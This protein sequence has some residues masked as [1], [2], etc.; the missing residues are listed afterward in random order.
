MSTLT[1]N[2]LTVQL[3][4]ISL[5]AHGGRLQ[6]KLFNNLKL[7]RTVLYTMTEENNV[8]NWIQDNLR[9]II[10]I[11]IVLLLVFAI[12]SY[13]KRNA[14]TGVIVD[15]SQINE[16][17]MTATNNNDEINQ[18]IDE[19]KD[20][21]KQEIAVTTTTPEPEGK[22]VEAPK[23]VAQEQPPTEVKTEEVPAVVAEEKSA[24]TDTVPVKEETAKD[25]VREV[26]ESHTEQPKDGVIKIVAVRGDS[27]TTLARKAAADYISKNN[28]SSITPAHKI[29]IED[30]LRK[31]Q[32]ARQIHP[33]TEMS[34][35]NA[36]IAEAVAKS[37]NLTEKQLSHL[38]TYA[39]HV[40][41]L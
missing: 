21:T 6:R 15:D 32:Q 24:K 26:I 38:D 34:F 19:I 7:E 35:T 8:S 9:I 2:I 23:T 28:I 39:K 13:S 22:G 33:G 5:S 40:S 41:Q 27:A 36:A 10:S 14:R 3:K 20:D 16:V 12:Y 29:Y 11:G 30:Y 1:H 4:E 17:A 25:V 18:I 37:Q 31:A